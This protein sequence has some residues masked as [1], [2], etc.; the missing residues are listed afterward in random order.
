MFDDKT[1]SVYNQN[2]DNY[3]PSLSRDSRDSVKYL[4]DNSPDTYRLLENSISN[5]IHQFL[6]YYAGAAI[7]FQSLSHYKASLGYQYPNPSYGSL[8]LDMISNRTDLY[9]SVWYAATS[10]Y[11]VG[12]QR[13]ASQVKDW[14]RNQM[15]NQTPIVVINNYANDVKNISF[16]QVMDNVSLENKNNKSSK[17][18]E[19]EKLL[20]IIDLINDNPKYKKQYNKF[21]KDQNDKLEEFKAIQVKKHSIYVEKVGKKIQDEMEEEDSILAETN[22]EILEE[23]EK[24]QAEKKKK[25]KMK[26]KQMAKLQKM[27]ATAKLE[28]DSDEE[29]ED[30]SE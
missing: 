28:M 27:V 30:S 22:K 1:M 8:F 5:N 9:G 29:D 13:D 2:A 6:V 15:K 26:T 12:Y 19:N 25:K 24:E 20:K 4:K 10:L 14:L 16:N 11:T 18:S 23:A 7:D 3:N 17:L 21:V